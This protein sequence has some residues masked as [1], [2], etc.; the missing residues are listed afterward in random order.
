M[1]VLKGDMGLLALFQHLFPDG[2][3][4]PHVASERTVGRQR[5]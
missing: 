4:R 2:P 3:R 5:S 1:L